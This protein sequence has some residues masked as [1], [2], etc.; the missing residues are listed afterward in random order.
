MEV[1]AAEQVPVRLKCLVWGV[2]GILP[3]GFE[4]FFDKESGFFFWVGPDGTASWD[5]PL[6]MIGSD[7]NPSI[8]EQTRH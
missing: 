1:L 7:P 2:P 6:G 4:E 8:V 5:P 3:D